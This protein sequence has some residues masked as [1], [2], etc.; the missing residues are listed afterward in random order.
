M[1]EHQ[2]IG[3]QP[4]STPADLLRSGRSARGLPDDLLRA[5]SQRLGI[6]SLLYAMLWVV[7][8][9]A[10]HFAGHAIMPDNPNWWLPDLGD[11]IAAISILV[12]LALYKYTRGDRNPRSILDLG[13]WYMVYT[14]LAIALTF[15]IGGIPPNFMI[16]PE[17]SWIGAVVLIFAAIVPARPKK[18]LVAGFI[19]VSMNPI[20]MLVLAKT[21]HWNFGSPWMALLMHYPDYILVGAAAVISA[22]VAKLGQQV[23]RAREM[24]S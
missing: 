20:S 3:P 1:A 18:M 7:G 4:V 13:L 19:A 6:M 23:T 10:G 22:V 15:H 14:G 24:G 2:L 21:Q 11:G 9:F 8:T 16:I 5:A 17:V 12:S